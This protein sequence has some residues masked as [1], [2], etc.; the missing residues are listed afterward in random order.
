ML[1]ASMCSMLL[2]LSSCFGTAAAAWS[3][4]SLYAELSE[5][6]L[7]R[8]VAG[9]PCMMAGYSLYSL[10]GC[11]VRLRDRVTGGV[12]P[13]KGQIVFSSSQRRKA[14]FVVLRITASWP[15]I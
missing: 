11:R 3:R 15:K 1:D 4:V 10:E 12:I 14:G 8:T 7:K 13:P 9:Y 2:V 6:Q 5:S